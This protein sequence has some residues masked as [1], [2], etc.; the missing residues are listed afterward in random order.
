MNDQRITIVC[1]HY[2]SGKTNLS[3]NL[4]LRA[5][6]VYPKTAV[7]DLDIVNPYFRTADFGSLFANHGIELIAPMF[8]NS[9]LDIPAIPA[10]L[11]GAIGDGER[12]LIIDVGGDDDGAVAL[13]G[14]SQ[15]L[16]EEGYEMLYVINRSR[17]L[18]DCPDE[19]IALLRSVE[20]C[21]RLSVTHLVNNTN[22]GGETTPALIRDS[23][24]YME[25]ISQRTGIPIGLTTAKQQIA[26]ALSD[27][28]NLFPIEVYVKTS[29]A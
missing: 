13:G 3:V 6:A 20:R 29:W 7:A 22:L 10:A 16:S 8:A 18:E 17:Y 5:A 15:R 27:I 19:E 23:M 14:F 2:G 11:R 9:N 4:A 26:G 28:P 12:H 21:S 25:E 24:A 1:G